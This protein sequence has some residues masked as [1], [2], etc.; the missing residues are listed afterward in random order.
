VINKKVIKQIAHLARLEL[1]EDEITSYTKDLDSILEYVKQLNEADTENVEPTSFMV[2][3]HNP[4]RDDV[5]KESLPKEKTLQNG[6]SIKKGF[7]AIPKVI[8]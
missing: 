6:P 5:E 8:Q 7:F 1:T 4:L 3:R 2:P